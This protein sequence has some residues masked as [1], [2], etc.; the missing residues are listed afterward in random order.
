[1]VSLNDLKNAID[2]LLALPV[3]G[4]LLKLNSNTSER[5]YEAYI[6]SLCV[7]AVEKAG[8]TVVLR[9]IKSG[10]NPPTLIFRGGPG[11]MSSREQDYCYAEC[12]LGRERFEIHVDVEYEGQSG[13]THEID[14]SICESNHCQNVRATGR[15]PRTRKN[16][17]M[18]FECKFY[19]DS[20]SLGV[21][22]ARTFVGLRSDC[23][24]PRLCAFVSNLTSQG[25][26]DYL[27]VSNRPKPF[28]LAPANPDSEE[29][30]VRAVEE[31]LRIWA[32][33]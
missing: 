8:G 15:L 6:F 17:I 19:G 23:T 9:G 16:L 18:L 20:G 7:K 2:N 25:I 13:A 5:A 29:L 1:M 26:R 11:S 4:Q 24:S 14:V 22:L 32:R 31:A 10:L 12:T 3:T 30:F 27:S 33:I 21:A 28:K